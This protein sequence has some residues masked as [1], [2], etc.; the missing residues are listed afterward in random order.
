[1]KPLVY[2][3]MNVPEEV[4][5]YIAQYCQIRKWDQEETIP[6]ERLLAEIGEA[7]GLLTT[8]GRIDDELFDHAPKLKVVSNVSVGYNNFDLEAMKRRK[9]IGTHTPGVLDETVADLAFA[10]MLAA[11]RRVPELDKMVKAGQWKNTNDRSFFGVDVHGK[12]LGI[13]GMGRIGEAIAR[14]ARFGFNMDVLYYNRNRKPDAEQRLEATYCTLEELLRQ[15]DFVVLVVPLT[16]ETR[17]LMGREQFALMKRTAIFVNVSRGKNVDEQALIEALQQG[18]ILA[19]GL[20]VFAEEPTPADNPLLQ[21]D[22]V[23]TLPHIGS[24]TAETRAAMAMLAAKN[25]VAGV[26]GQVPEHIVPE[27]R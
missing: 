25:L 7:E 26:T 23:V 21:M 17:H 19:A 3:T 15:A 20:D 13:I 18:Q 14:R 27:L 4:E 22:N 6:R 1:M 2:L 8:G 11:A 10:L 9:I 24:A 5:K 16:P 12:R